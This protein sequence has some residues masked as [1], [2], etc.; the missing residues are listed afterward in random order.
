MRLCNAA[1]QRTKSIGLPKRPL[2]LLM[3]HPRAAHRRTLVSDLRQVE[4]SLSRYS[5]LDNRLEV[6]E[7]SLTLQQDLMHVSRR[8]E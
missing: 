5:S 8:Y 7:V 1:P 4:G 3:V 2:V 6:H